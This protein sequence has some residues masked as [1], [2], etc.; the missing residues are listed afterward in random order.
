MAGLPLRLEL[1]AEAE[2]INPQIR[3][4]FVTGGEP[5]PGEEHRTLV[6]PFET[7]DMRRRILFE[8]ALTPP[9]PAEPP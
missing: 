5:P 4:L 9:S 1:A 3:V 2:R 8:L 7:L 6:K